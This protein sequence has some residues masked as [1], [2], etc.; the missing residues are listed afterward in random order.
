MVLLQVTPRSR[1]F[2][3]LVGPLWV[4]TVSLLTVVCPRPSFAQTTPRVDVPPECGS[5]GAFMTAVAELQGTSTAQL[6]VSEVE[7]SQHLQTF[8]LR[9]TTAEGLRVVVDPDCHALFRTATI[10]AATLARPTGET[11]ASRP[12]AVVGETQEDAA[13]VP[14][15]PAPEPNPTRTPVILRQ[16]QS[17]APAP[18]PVPK[19]EP[20]AKHSEAAFELAAGAAG[21]VGL[22]P[23]PHVG[24]EILTGLVTRHWG[25]HLAAR[26]LP[27]RSMTV[28]DSLGLRQT[29]WGTR[30]SVSRMAQPWLR[31]SLGMSA[32]W[33]SAQGLGI[34]EPASDGVGLLAP[35]VELAAK[36]VTEPSFQGEVAL[37][38]HAGLS[39]PRFE[40]EPAGVIYELPRLGAACVFRIM[41]TSR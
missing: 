32:Y 8:E 28:R 14:S 16:P 35:E 31:V 17:P 25:A 1:W 23:K 37:Q 19:A 12:T 27:P 5:P 38:G 22:T 15:A 10:I 33:I 29:V 21:H 7:I 13:T 20:E 40:V 11:P 4:L 34:T 36:V 26:V 41:W 24:I 30:L 3:A 39:R 2:G 18:S 6:T 9:M